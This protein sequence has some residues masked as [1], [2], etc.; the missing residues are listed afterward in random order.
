MNTIIHEE[1]ET[2]VCNNPDMLGRQEFIDKVITLLEILS[3]KKTNCCF[4]IDGEWGS[5]K[6]FVLNMLQ[7]QIEKYCSEETGGD[8]YLVFPYNCWEYDYY[9]EPTVAIVASMKDSIEE[10]ESVISSKGDYFKRAKDVILKM[11]G[12]FIK[13]K[14]GVDIVGDI[15]ELTDDAKKNEKDA[16]KFDAFFSF[17]KTLDETRN[18]L[19]ELAKDKTIILIVDELDRCLPAYAIKVLERLHH[20]FYGIDNIIVVIAVDSSQLENSVKQLY[21]DSINV[22]QYLKKFIDFTLKLGKGNISCNFEEK[23]NEYFDCFDVCGEQEDIIF[24]NDLYKNLCCGLSMREQEKLIDAAKTIHLILSKNKKY[25]LSVLCYELINTF[26]KYFTGSILYFQNDQD[27]WN[28]L[29]KVHLEF[30]LQKKID[31]VLVEK[32]VQEGTRTYYKYDISD[33]DIMGKT[34][35][36]LLKQYVQNPTLLLNY[37]RVNPLFSVNQY[38]GVFTLTKEF[39]S[40]LNFID[41]GENGQR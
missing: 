4:A 21:G 41:V 40:F 5:G 2:I 10:K 24:L 8:K 19:E 12:T 23:Y 30:F 25:N 32:C 7:K 22:D 38:E 9:E 1:I 27:S 26:V 11:T 3:K 6:S 28:K 36:L 39:D 33:S 20:L 29:N 35:I 15:Q 31:Q 17:K 18:S 16:H 13:N 37:H 34:C 14:I